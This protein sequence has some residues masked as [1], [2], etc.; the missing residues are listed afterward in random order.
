VSRRDDHTYRDVEQPDPR[1]AP[2]HSLGRNLV[3]AV[4][5]D[6]YTAWPALSNAVSD[7]HGALKLLSGLGFELAAPPLIDQ[8]A[9]GKAL[10]RLAT[11]DLTDIGP[12]D[13]LERI[14]R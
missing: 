11:D 12:E 6:T 13:S 5:I 10:R 2:V 4:G 3:A 14:T 9:I 7:A 8:A 1:Q